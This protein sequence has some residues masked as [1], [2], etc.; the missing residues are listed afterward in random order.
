MP[1]ADANRRDAQVAGSGDLVRDSALPQP[2]AQKGLQR[3]DGSQFQRSSPSAP[4]RGGGVC[5]QLTALPGWTSRRNSQMIVERALPMTVPDRGRFQAT[6]SVVS[7][8]DPLVLGE[9]PR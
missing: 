7:D 3:E 5:V 9:A 2:D 6:A 4:R 1:T 8:L